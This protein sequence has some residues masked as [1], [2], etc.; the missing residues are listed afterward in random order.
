MQIHGVAAV[1]ALFLVWWLDIPWSDVLLVFFSIG[2]VIS[3]ELVNTAV[4]ATVDLITTEHHPK[5]KLAK[6]AAAGAVLVAAVVSVSV[7]LLVFG[8]PLL[9]KLKNLL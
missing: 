8:Q 6:D 2:L 9:T 3:L 1:L 5:A 7:G 4:E